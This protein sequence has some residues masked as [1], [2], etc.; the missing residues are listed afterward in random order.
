MKINFW[1]AQMRNYTKNNKCFK[2][3]KTK[4]IWLWKD[5]R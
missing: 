1:V 2:G 3:F 5:K 4:H